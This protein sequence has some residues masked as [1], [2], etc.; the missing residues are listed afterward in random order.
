MKKL[1]LLSFVCMLIHV[2][3]KKEE[4][5]IQNLNGGRI[6]SMGHGGMGIYNAYP[7]NS[8]ASILSALN[9]DASGSEMDVQ[10]TR[11]SVL[12]TYHG[13]DLSESTDL[14]G[15]VHAHT[16]TELEQGHYN[17]APY[18]SLPIMRLDRLFENLDDRYD[19]QYTFD[20]KLHR[21]TNDEPAYNA[22]F[23]RQLV[24]LIGRFGIASNVML[25]SQ[26]PDMLS[27]L[28]TLDPTLR[29]FIYPTD[30]DNGLTIAEELGLFG[31]TISMEK[32]S[33]EQ[34][35]TAHDHGLWVALW[36]VYTKSD[37]EDAIRKNPEVI[38][39]DRLDHLVGLLE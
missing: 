15:L 10:M 25:E 9:R 35:R 17:E 18:Q 1:L 30:F 28:K 11:D 20:I 14:D 3:C 7:L 37:N 34:V 38:Q 39:T 32:I 24:Q 5:D 33:A 16:W 12:V 2:R 23:A 31:I 13:E 22:A 26:V 21:S 36:D 27:R 4:F 6:L 8:S 29:L 19:H